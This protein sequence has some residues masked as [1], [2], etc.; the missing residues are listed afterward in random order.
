MTLV[1]FKKIERYFREKAERN[2]LEKARFLYTI[3][4]SHST[5][6]SY[7]MALEYYTRVLELNPNHADALGSIG[8]ILLERG[9]PKEALKFFDRSLSINPHD[10]L[11]LI[12]KGHAL[13]KLKRY[14]EAIQCLSESL[15][16]RSKLLSKS[17]NN[18]LEVEALMALGSSFKRMK[19]YDA[20]I[21]VYDQVLSIEPKNT[22]AL[23]NKAT[24][25]MGLH[26]DD[27]LLLCLNKILE[28]NPGDKEV[29]ALLKDLKTGSSDFYQMHKKKSRDPSRRR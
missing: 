16:L 15:G 22:D 13:N 20:T 24:S 21:P 28:I 3:G 4:L 8:G 29:V 10:K 19:L 26:R 9:K 14:E 25:L 17:T 6:R 12:D 27:E 11:V 23:F 18:F 1:V 7:E 2:R 5:N